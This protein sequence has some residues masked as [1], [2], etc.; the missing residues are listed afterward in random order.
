MLKRKFRGTI[1]YRKE[2]LAFALRVLIEVIIQLLFGLDFETLALIMCTVQIRK[3]T[4]VEQNNV[5]LGSY[6]VVSPEANA[7][8][9]HKLFWFLLL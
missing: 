4:R 7:L 9:P 5:F 2:T 3:F 8:P 1:S 6:L